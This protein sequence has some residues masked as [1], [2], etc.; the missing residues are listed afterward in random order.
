MEPI[1][2]RPGHEI[3]KLNREIEEQ[4]SEDELEP[5]EPLDLRDTR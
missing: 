2:Y 5:W 3:E 1:D 4:Y